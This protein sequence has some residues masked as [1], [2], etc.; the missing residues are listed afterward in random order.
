MSEAPGSGFFAKSLRLGTSPSRSNF[1]R[2][3]ERDASVNTAAAPLFG[4][5]RGTG[6][7]LCLPNAGG[8][9]TSSSGY[10]L[11]FLAFRSVRNRD[12]FIYINV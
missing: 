9:G 4:L 1:S 10:H 3:R 11:Q 5:G 12:R 6:L 2:Y 7:F 8:L